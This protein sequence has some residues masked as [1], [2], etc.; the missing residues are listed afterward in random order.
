MGRVNPCQGLLFRRRLLNILKDDLVEEDVR[1]THLRALLFEYGLTSPEEIA[2]PIENSVHSIYGW[3][4]N[5]RDRLELRHW[6]R[7]LHYCNLL[8]FPN[9]EAPDHPETPHGYQAYCLNTQDF[10]ILLFMVMWTNLISRN[11]T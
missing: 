4:L 2:F 9:L 8:G 5:F 7:A 10:M 11:G 1:R 6:A 3:I